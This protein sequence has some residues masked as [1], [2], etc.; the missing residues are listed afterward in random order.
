MSQ[1]INFIDLVGQYQRHKVDIDAAMHGVIE[2]GAFVLGPQVSQLEEQLA[3]YVG[4]KHCV[5][6]ASG[7]DSL[8]LSLYALGIGPGDEVITVPF[9][10]FSTAE[11]ITRSGATPVFIDIEPAS[12]NMNVEQLA[13]AITPNTKA[14]MPVSLFGQ[15][16]DMTAIEAIAAEKGIAVIE[17][18]AQSFGATHN[19]KRSSSMSTVGATS[20]Y[21]TK[22]LGCYGDG[23]AVFTDDDTLAESIRHRRVHGQASPQNHTVLGMNSRLDTIQAAVLLEKLKFFD[24]EVALR[25]A[26]GAYYSQHLADHATVPAISH[27]NTHV[28]AQYTLRVKNRDA[29]LAAIR[30]AGVPCGVYY[31]KVIHQ[32]G[33][34]QQHPCR[35]TDLQESERAAAEVLSLP[36]HPYLEREQQD[37]IITVVKEAL[38]SA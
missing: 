16:A 6:N 38:A 15:M 27:G 2:S 26:V 35:F 33:I 29:V 13:E 4:V 1:R 32:Q 30:Q 36:M 22:P 28:Y 14:I 12:F 18:G 19:G 23:G 21:P 5:A 24:R 11:V 34:Y 31:P 10:W 7:T 8:L 3:T 9:T 37:H 17:D 25:Q 20:F